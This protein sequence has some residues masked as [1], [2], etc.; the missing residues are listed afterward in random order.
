MST[1]TAPPPTTTAPFAAPD[2]TWRDAVT[3]LSRSSRQRWTACYGLLL[4]LLAASVVGRTFSIE[5]DGSEQIPLILFV[6]LVVVFGMLRRGTRRIAALDHPDLDERDIDACN[7]AYRIAFP[8][9]VLVVL[10]GL[11]LL[12]MVAPESTRASSAGSVGTALTVEWEGLIALGLWIGL[13]AVFLPTGVLAWSEPDALEAEEGGGAL[14]ES[15]RDVLLGLALAAG[16]AA[17]LFTNTGFGFLLFIWALALLGALAR[18]A[19]GQ[20]V[21]SRQRRWRLAIGLTM[22]LIL[23][24]YVLVSGRGGSSEGGIVDDGGSSVEL[25][26]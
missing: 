18:R 6:A 4:V 19:G 9:L 25:T 10:L 17:D 7:R 22:I 24:A 26:K 3:P 13:W 14:S 8:L 1:M 15:L 5:A 20:P 21:I 2:V 11:V 16:L 23:A 12:A